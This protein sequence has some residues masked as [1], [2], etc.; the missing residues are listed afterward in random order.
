MS[1]KRKLFEEVGAAAATRPAAQPGLIDKRHSGARKAIRVWLQILFALVFIMIAV[2]GLTRLTDSGLSITEW[3]PLTGALPPLSEAEWQSEFEKYQAIDEFRIQN[4]WMQMA[5]FKVIYWWEWGHRQLGRVIG[6][7]WALGFGYFLVRRQVPAGW[8][9]KLLFLGLLGGAQGAI[10]WWMVASGVTQG[11]GVTD[12]ASYRLATHLGL[13]FVILGFIAWYIMELG[14][15]A[16][17]LMQARRIKEGKQWGM[18]TGL[19]HFTFLQILLGALVAGI[20]AGRSYT[21]WPMMGGQWFPSTALVLEPIWR[22]FF[23]SPGLVQFMHRV[24]GYVL[25]LFT[26]V[27]WLRGRRSSHPHT[28]FAFNA[29]LAAMTLQIVLG[30]VTVL[31]GAPAHIAIFHQTLAVIVWVLILRARFLSGYPIATS[32]RG[33]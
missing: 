27:V 9:G 7:V 8:H 11:E 32:V 14:R 4:Q 25:I 16:P 18:S 33:T 23:E 17:D 2:G 5:D 10:G 30:I 21:D 12:V 31:Y 15:S 13:A 26:V 20:D 1:S 19:L 22:N 28:R 24:T 29:V 6:V 3:R